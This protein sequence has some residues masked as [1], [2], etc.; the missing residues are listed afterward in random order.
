M[1]PANEAEG[2]DKWPTFTTESIY[3][4]KAVEPTVWCQTPE[5]LTAPQHS[6]IADINTIPS[7]ASDALGPD[8]NVASAAMSKS[9]SSTGSSESGS[10]YMNTTSYPPS[11]TH[12]VKSDLTNPVQHPPYVKRPILDESAQWLEHVLMALQVVDDTARRPNSSVRGILD[13]ILT[14]GD[15]ALC[16]KIMT[17]IT[18]N[19]EK[20][21]R[22]IARPTFDAAQERSR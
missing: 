8:L 17:T 3:Q 13:D 9:N 6:P 15:F 1:G 16:V 5:A 10:M 7:E 4:D 22:Y 2:L 21:N 18:E 14:E 19:W 11:E 12:H 20:C